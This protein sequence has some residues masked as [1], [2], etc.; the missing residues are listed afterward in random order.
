MP[1]LDFSQVHTYPLASRRN[2]VHWD[3][4]VW[5]PAPVLASDAVPVADAVP[6]E[7]EEVITRIIAARQ[8]SKAVIWNMGAHV[9]KCG[10]SPLL[11]DLM[12]RGLLTHIAG[13]GAVSI[14]DFELCLIGQTSEDVPNGLEDGSFGMAEETS[15]NMHQALRA[16]VRDGL[17]YGA[18][19]GR[20]IAERPELFPYRQIGV[21]YNAYRLGI[22]A[23]IHATIGTD[24]IHQHPAAD[25]SVI[26]A[27]SGQDFRTF[28]ASV[29]ELE[30]G[31]FLNFGSAVTGP[32]VFLKAL[33]VV[34]NLGFPVFHIT[35][36][37]FDLRPL[38]DY[39][40]PVADSEPDYYYRPRK[41]II[42]RPTAHGGK[43]FHVNADHKV[44]I[45]YIHQRLVTAL[46]SLPVAGPGAAPA[47]DEP[48]QEL[49]AP[50]LQATL[51]DLQRAYRSI[52]RCLHSGGTLFLAGNG[53]SMADALHISGE[54]LKSFAQARPLPASLAQKLAAPPDGALLARNLQS[55]M[56]AIGLG[57]NPALSS[58]VANDMPDR[59]VNLAQEVLALA[60]PG[61][62]F[63]GI[64]TSGNARN[65][66]LAAQTARA[67]GLETIAL[68]GAG[69]GKLSGLVDVPVRVPAQDTP[70]VQ[71]FH[72]QCY[73]A[74]CEW[75]EQAWITRS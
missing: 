28:T 64:S 23:T 24:I 30:G 54:L 19:L 74:L 5:P 35:T 3:D 32:E 56:R 42:N 18:S 16:G 55:G 38:P 66:C 36:A 41:N 57:R 25:F 68:T 11:V 40:A 52:L 60:R 71:E 14:H 20:F 37:N 22:P 73:H 4:L 70:R 45:P 13:N 31:V 49:S 46:G 58:A 75:L 2:L 50:A 47:R 39:R 34:R 26:G 43:G 15:A 1:S 6:V 59:D 29:S 72:I 17:G 7:L 53:G 48:P 61:D 21:L 65:I 67:L 44:T 69:G 27:A 9:I 62:V 51:P 8:A 63:L 10:L 12:Q 33:T